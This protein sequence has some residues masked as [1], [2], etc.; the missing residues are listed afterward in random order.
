[1]LAA[2]LLWLLPVQ[3]APPAPFPAIQTDAPTIERIAPGVEY[4]TYDLLTAAGPLVVH[5]VAVK[6]HDSDVRLGTVLAHD[7]LTSP[8]ERIS[9]M[10]QRTG[11]VAGINGDYFDIGQSNRPTNLV[12]TGGTL[13]QTPNDRCALVVTDDGMPHIVSTISFLGQ[14]QL[15]HRTV[16]IESIN[17]LPSNGGVALL[18]PAYGSVPPRDDL[19]V[20]A[21]APMDGTPPFATYRVEA[22]S[23]NLQTQPPGYYALIGMNAYGSTGVPRIGEAIAASGDLSPIPLDRI[24]SAVGGGPLILKHGAW[25]DDPHGPSGGEFARPIPSSGAAIAPD[26]TLFL[27]EVDGRQ[28]EFSVG[29][30]R[31]EFAALMLALGATRGMSF[32]GGG[33]SEIAVRTLARARAHVVNS[34]SDG[35][36]RRVADGV[37]VYSTLPVGPM[38]GLVS[39]R[40]RLRAMPGARI[41][42]RIANVD[43]ADHVVTSAIPI[44][45]AVEPASLGTF[46]DGVFTAAAPGQGAI[47][48]RSGA[49]TLTIPVRVVADPAHLVIVPRHPAVAANATIALRAYAYDAHGYALALPATLP[50]RTTSGTIT[51]SGTLTVG[52]ADAVISL[53][54]GEHVANVRVTVGF[55]DVALPFAAAAHFMSIPPDGPGT[56]T[57]QAGCSGCIALHYA[58]GS[59]ER[60][61]YAAAKTLLP[62]G[63]RGLSF[64][65]FDDGSGALVKIALRNALGEEVLLPA[66]RLDRPG[67]RRV[68][69]GFPD[70]LLQ[71]ARLDAMYVI[72]PPS[73]PP[74]TGTIFIKNV[75]A[76]VAGSQ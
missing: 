61:A 2:L 49:A 45:A 36:E 23:D 11:A 9:S 60:A 66:T 39:N 35:K 42:V 20:V 70:D 71:P 21:L 75:K 56:V 8:G 14:L 10:A 65:L 67:W 25:F 32:D 16:P 51:P 12:V 58:L 68:F 15:Q 33:S 52:T 22:I 13:L 72:A 64:T 5:V 41:G 24:Q 29:I 43:N 7:A 76:V 17:Q 31:P 4:G 44:R 54:L 6:P 57:Q 30:T 1:M 69:V 59:D 62:E 26:G 37:F 55:H 63:S 3:L 53:L 19:T 38:S 46:A 47:V 48:A 74:A 28:P 27:I 34:P 18:T 73:S 50:W 40:Q